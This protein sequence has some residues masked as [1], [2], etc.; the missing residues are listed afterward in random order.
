[1]IMRSTVALGHGIRLNEQL[2]KTLGVEG[3]AR[4]LF[5]STQM[6]DQDIN[7]SMPPAD[8][9]PMAMAVPVTATATVL[10]NQG[11]QHMHANHQPKGMSWNPNTLSGDLDRDQILQ[12]KDQGFPTGL[13][14]EMGT[15]RATY[16]L[17]FWVVD[18]SGSMR[19]NDGHELR[20]TAQA[21]RVVD[22]NRWKELQGSVA[23]HIELA[24]L[25]QATTI[26]RLLNHPGVR[27]GQ[28]EF[29]VAEN[30]P[31]RT[32]IAQEVSRAKAIIQQ[33]EPRGV[34]PLTEHLRVIRQRIES[35]QH[36]LN[37][38]G[39]QAVIVL[40]TDGLPSNNQGESTE[41]VRQEFIQALK[42]LQSLPVWVVVRLCTDDDNVVDYYNDLDNVLELPLEVIDDFFGEGKEIHAANKWLNYTLPLHRCREMG[43]HHRVF[44]LL[45]E[46][47]LN[48]DE[49][50]VF[51]Q[52]V[53]GRSAMDGAPDPHADWKGFHDWV[54]RIVKAEPKQFNPNTKKS[55][56]WIDL[57]QL[58]KSY[59]KGGFRLFRKKH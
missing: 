47:L 7:L 44:D 26:F 25:L 20:G 56:Y 15:T 9:V 31:D 40:A 49:L 51:L 18:N 55:E 17:R 10:P 36:I 5:L 54:S 1:M 50:V 57:K 28:Q 32:L 19:T 53:F 22:C 8:Q 41:Y 2:R 33:S 24:G 39:Q 21:L 35:V 27:A 58:D 6:T 30:G 42:S 34:T 52:L 13:A 23:Y 14:Q 29:S 43:Y 11:T 12:L 37:S 4:T 38:Q 46:R 45:D 48:K 3:L 59:G 16:P